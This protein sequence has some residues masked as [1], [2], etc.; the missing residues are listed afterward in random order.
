MLT[1]DDFQGA[2]VTQPSADTGAKAPRETLRGGGNGLPPL[3]QGDTTSRALLSAWNGERVTLVQSPPGGGK[4]TLLTVLAAYLSRSAQLRVGIACQRRNQAEDVANRIGALSPETKATLVGAKHQNRPRGLAPGVNYSDTLHDPEDPIKDK[5]VVIA[6]S[7]KL[8]FLDADLWTFDVILVDEAWQLDY[9]G[10]LAMTA[11]TTQFVLVGDPGQ[12]DP[13]VVGNTARWE[14]MR[15]APHVAAPDVVRR[16]FD[17]EVLSLPSSRRNGPAT[18]HALQP[19]YPFAFDSA[20]PERTLTVDGNDAAEVE[21]GTM[22]TP[23]TT[24][25]NDPTLLRAVADRARHLVTDGVFRNEDGQT[26][27]LSEEDV[28]V[29]VPFVTQATAVKALLSDMPNVTVDTVD[30]LQGGEWI[31]TVVLNPAAGAAMPSS[32]NCDLGRLCV[33]LS[34]HIA[35]CT[36]V[37]PDGTAEQVRH[38]P[39]IDDETRQVFLEAVG[40]ITATVAA[41][42]VEV[43]AA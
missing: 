25:P 19:L 18:V 7:A 8:A 6:S 37:E 41:P 29:V 9:A 16:T 38:S 14:G 27:P 39:E 2:P 12:V 20:R 42:T 40:R 22:T 34:R 5:G 43:A 4:T 15:E 1:L 28:A 21:I 31:A 33:S 13:I 3:V 26:R 17:P 11:I 36:M 32:F 23:R 30:T 35:H 24:N 10:L